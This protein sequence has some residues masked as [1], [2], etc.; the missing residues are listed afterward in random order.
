MFL[1]FSP[2]GWRDLKNCGWVH[3]LALY[4]LSSDP[5][6]KRAGLNESEF[7]DTLSVQSP[8]TLP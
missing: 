4:T 7:T 8:A 6:K 3:L 5:T 1:I 2:P